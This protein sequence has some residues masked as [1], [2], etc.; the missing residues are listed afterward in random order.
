[1]KKKISTAEHAETAAQTDWN[2][3]MMEKWNNGFGYFYFLPIIPIFHYSFFPCSVTSVVKF[4][5][6]SSPSAGFQ[7]NPCFLGLPVLFSFIILAFSL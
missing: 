6:Y 4:F 7:N 1:M 3:G 5:H 2:A